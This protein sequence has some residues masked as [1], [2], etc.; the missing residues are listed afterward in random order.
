VRSSRIVL[1]SIALGIAAAVAVLWVG[2]ED[3]REPIRVE[4]NRVVVT[5]LGETDWSGVE[6]WLNDWY[7]AQA[8]RVVAGQR[9]DVPFT[10]FLAAYD[11]PYDPARQPPLGVE[12]TARGDD[13][14]A[15]K[16]IWGQGRRR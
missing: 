8:P 10:A 5:N 14:S 12:V 3:R 7:R 9:L 2:G 13:G 16:L 11:R 6:I 15:V 1:L 4:E